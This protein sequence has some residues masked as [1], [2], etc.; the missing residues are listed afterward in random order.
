MQ[1]VI[2][3]GWNSSL[4]DFP[5]HWLRI[6]TRKSKIQ[7]G[8]IQYGRPKYKKCFYLDVTQHLRAI[9]VPGYESKLKIQ[10]LKM[11]KQHGGPKFKKWFDLN[12]EFNMANRN[13]KWF[14]W[15]ETRA[16][17]ICQVTDYEFKLEFQKFKMAKSNLADQNTKNISIQI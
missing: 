10:N 9:E 17:R 14:D 11:A 15:D 6:G 2:R 1:K 8:E 7:N 3:F 16:S 13:A 5:D 12:G 4:R